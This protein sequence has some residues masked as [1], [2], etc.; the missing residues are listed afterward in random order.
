MIPLLAPVFRGPLAPYG[1]T[2]QH[3]ATVP[4]GAL[5]LDALLRSTTLL[6]HA[7]QCHARHLGA[8]M[9]HPRPVAS[10]WSLRYLAALLPPMVA[11]AS[12]LHHVFPAAADRIWLRLDANGTPAGFHI[13]TLGHGLPGT[14]TARRYAPL[15][16]EH[17]APLFAAL[18]RLSDLPPKILWG[19]A[20]RQLEPILMQALALSAGSA[21]VTRD[22]QWLLHTRVWADNRDA[23]QPG[24]QTNPLHG[25]RREVLARGGDGLQPL[26]LHRQCCL[27]H[28]LPGGRHCG[29][30]PLAPEHSKA[31]L[32]AAAPGS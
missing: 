9:R 10:A 32:R 23:A 18:G 13:Q 29:A 17:L 16:W 12:V 27:Q 28:L 2:L 22:R 26:Q 30:C 15:L 7:L 6:A 20:A 11:G 24:T 3:A 1:E 4:P 5:R 8:D 21:A 19:N 25:R 14:D 31:A